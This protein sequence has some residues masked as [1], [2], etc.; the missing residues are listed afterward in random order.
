MTN[1]YDELS[2]RARWF[3]E[4]FDE[5]DLAELCAN[6]EAAINRVRHLGDLIE[7][8]APWTA[9]HDN[10][11][12]RI[13]DALQPPAEQPPLEHAAVPVDLPRTRPTRR[14]QR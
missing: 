13:R 8:G 10:L 6:Q 1:R 11:A 14:A 9:N 12:R 4:N 5:L 3:M 2:D 7:T